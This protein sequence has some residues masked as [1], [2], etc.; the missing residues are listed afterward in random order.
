MACTHFCVAGT[1]IAFLRIKGQEAQGTQ[2]TWGPY[3]AALTDQESDTLL[4]LSWLP[5][6]WPLRALGRGLGLGRGSRL[7]WDQESH[8]A[9]ESLLL[10]L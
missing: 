2:L 10:G 5:Q 3:T 8:L 1:R 4:D 6:A 7:V 9:T